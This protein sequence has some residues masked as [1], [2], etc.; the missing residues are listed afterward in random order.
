MN[1]S[2][3]LFVILSL[4]II[5][6]GCNKI[7]DPG[8]PQNYY[9]PADVFSNDSLL[10]DAIW[11]VKKKI[12]N[13]F[14]FFN[15]RSSRLGGLAADEL[16]NS[17]T[18]NEDVPFLKN[19]IHPSNQLIRN[20]WQDNY[21]DI[22]VLN[23]LIMGLSD[24]P[25][26]SPDL[27]LLVLGEA[28]FLRGLY[29]F[30]FINFFGDV[31]L[32][33]NT[34]YT[35]NAKM[36]RTPSAQVY[37]QIISDLKEAQK[38]LPLN[39]TP[40][41]GY[42]GAR[43]NASKL[44]ATALLARVYLFTQQWTLAEAAATDVINSPLYRLETDMNKVFLAGSSETIFEFVSFN[45]RFNTGA[46]GMFVPASSS[47]RPPVIFTDTF[48]GKI[49]PGDQRRQWIRSAFFGATQYHS[50]YK[51][52]VL[53]GSPYTEHNIVLRLA[54][55]YLIRAEALAQQ[56]RATEAQG[57]LSVIRSRAGLPVS[58]QEILTAITHERSIEFFA[59]WGSRWLDLTRLPS[60]ANPLDIHRRLA[61][62][63]LETLKP[64]TWGA[65][66]KRWPVPAYELEQNSSLVQNPGY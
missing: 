21:K 43:A 61:D 31:P 19:D 41:E 36:P 9:L 64:D 57:D 37:E 18:V 24:N 35:V 47:V 3:K 59:E 54:E 6:T 51:Y 53:G 63:I 40:V 14:S 60:Q 7:L 50:P 15:G 49:E 17:I 5:A 11:H 34:D 26:I 13:S 62:D 58:Q 22:Y 32:V 20:I 33:T 12:M 29:Y 2:R 16:K 39:Y 30:Y 42:T 52:K 45:T 27:R 48:L 66:D 46:A 44:V 38:L 28:Y 25:K 23:E 8:L 4:A 55:Q 65:T 56:G 1:I 10:K